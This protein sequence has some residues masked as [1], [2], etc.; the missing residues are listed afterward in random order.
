[1]S[2][3]E[4]PSLKK[5]YGSGRVGGWRASCNS[6]SYEPVFYAVPAEAYELLMDKLD[7]TELVRYLSKS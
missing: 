3:P 6:E 7:A 5:P 2:A 4:Y 1:M